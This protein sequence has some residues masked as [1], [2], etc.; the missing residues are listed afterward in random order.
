M[1]GAN[2]ESVFAEALEIEDLQARAAFLDRA[3]AGNPALRKSVQS[4]L[5]A[6]GAGQFLELPAPVPN[7]TTDEP[8]SERPGTV[9]GTPLTSSITKYGRPLVVSPPSSTLAIFV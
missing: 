6:Y 9:I 3:C 5:S 8:I 7:A 1:T 2:E 4:L